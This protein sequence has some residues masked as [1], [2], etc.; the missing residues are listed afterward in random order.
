MFGGT[1]GQFLG[2]PPTLGAVP[3]AGD[4]V[5]GVMSALHFGTFAGFLSRM[6]WFGLGLVMSYVTV[7]GLQLWLKRRAD[8]LTWR[9][10]GRLVLATV[11]GLPI[12][13]CGATL[14]FFLSL[15]SQSTNFWTATGFLVAS[16]GCLSIAW[17]ISDTDRLRRL[18]RVVLGGVLL[19]LPIVRFK[20]SDDGWIQL[21]A[22]QNIAVVVLDFTL[23]LAGAGLLYV[24]CR[25]TGTPSQAPRGPEA[26]E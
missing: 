2:S 6:I 15:P 9:R 11:Y 23:L 16:A 13:L 3:S 21:S 7:T 5:F 25:P 10:I 18:C 26:A 14:A 20:I 1:T 22:S 24:T 12:A 19:S 4:T 17:W 8:D